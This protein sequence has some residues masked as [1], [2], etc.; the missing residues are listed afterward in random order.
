MYVSVEHHMPLMC[1]YCGLRLTI[2]QNRH[3]EECRA[4]CSKCRAAPRDY[5]HPYCR[6]CKAFYMKDH[7]RANPKT[8]DELAHM[9]AAA[10]INTWV[11]R[12]KIERGACEAPGCT[13]KRTCAYHRDARKPAEVQF[14]CRTHLKMMRAGKLRVAQKHTHD[15]ESEA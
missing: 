8:G 10:L 14:F 13:K 5:P 9:R 12:G 7:R 11:R 3:C 6:A 1:R 2:G 15:K 4:Q